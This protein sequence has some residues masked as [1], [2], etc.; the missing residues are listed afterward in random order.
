M[1][2]TFTNLALKNQLF[3]GPVIPY[4]KKM[5]ISNSR[6]SHFSIPC[7]HASRRMGI[8]HSE[9]TKFLDQIILQSKRRT[10]SSLFQCNSFSDI[11]TDKK[12]SC[13]S[14]SMTN[15]HIDRCSFKKIV[16]SSYPACFLIQYSK[17]IVT[18]CSFQSSYST[19]KSD[20]SF[21]NAYECYLCSNLVKYSHTLLCAPSLE[22]YGDSAIALV[23]STQNIVNFLNSTK[24]KGKLGGASITIRESTC[25][26]NNFSYLTIV[27]PEDFSAFETSSTKS[28]F[29][30]YANFV[31]CTK[32]I[33][34]N[35]HNPNTESLSFFQAFFINPHPVFANTLE[36]I[37]MNNCYTN[38]LQLSNTYSISTTEKTYPIL[39][40]YSFQECTILQLSSKKTVRILLSL[41]L[42]LI[43]S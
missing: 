1:N 11:R 43:L 20:R 4:S 22:E 32:C 14:F 34:C 39:I 7:I 27:E 25:E 2:L 28:T 26:T 30:N 33:V 41:Q 3:H 31:N 16:S 6:F 42:F 5:E 24:C 12:G 9:F 37:H 8:F 18:K 23:E 15:I 38:S 13:F 17:V 35:L 29:V 40:F 21:G 10:I 19:A 36:T